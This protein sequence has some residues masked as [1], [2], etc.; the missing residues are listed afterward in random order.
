M[1]RRIK[2]LF[3]SEVTRWCQLLQPSDFFLDPPNYHAGRSI[4]L[5]CRVEGARQELTYL[6]PSNCTHNCFVKVR[7]THRNGLYSVD[8]DTHMC[9][10]NGALGPSGNGWNASINQIVALV[11]N[12]L[13][14]IV[15]TAQNDPLFMSMVLSNTKMLFV[16]LGTGLY[17]VWI[18][19]HAHLSMKIKP[20]N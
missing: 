4:T 3:L 16:P 11:I 19:Y 20:K 18:H 15:T 10:V 1:A 12:S 9:I 17:D 6:S 13:Q 2:K 7:T 5:T 8:S 14:T